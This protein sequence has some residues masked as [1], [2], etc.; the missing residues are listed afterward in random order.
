MIS[1]G[2][3]L[4]TH[5]LF[6][7]QLAARRRGPDHGGVNLDRF[8]SLNPVMSLN[9]HRTVRD[10]ISKHVP[11]DVFTTMEEQSLTLLPHH[12]GVDSLVEARAELPLVFDSDNAQQSGDS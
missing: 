3:L 2:T 7:R 8:S 11:G 12:G 1:S 4:L 5:L 9:R 6:S 10:A